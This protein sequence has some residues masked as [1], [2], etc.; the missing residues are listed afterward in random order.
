MGRARTFKRLRKLAKYKWESVLT[1][2]YANIGYIICSN[3][4][5]RGAYRKIKALFREG[6]I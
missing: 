4:S 6:K 3:L 5:P 2:K 1:R